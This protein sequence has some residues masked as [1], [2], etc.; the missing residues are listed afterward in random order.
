[1]DAV[2]GLSIAQVLGVLA[3][4][5]AI[6]QYPKT[7][8]ALRKHRLQVFGVPWEAS[9]HLQDLVSA[10]L[11]V[12]VGI[13]AL[14]LFKYD[15]PVWATHFVPLATIGVIVV[16]TFLAL[17]LR[18]TFHAK[19]FY[20]VVLAPVFAGIAPSMQSTIATLATLDLSKFLP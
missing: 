8:W 5:V 3:I 9:R 17:G 10:N 11:F 6:Q 2:Q 19:R 4:A 14:G 15:I 12:S 18:E 13:T 7:I 1:M 20:T 16:Y